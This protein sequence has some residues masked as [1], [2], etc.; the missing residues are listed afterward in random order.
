MDKPKEYAESFQRTPPVKNCRLYCKTPKA[1]IPNVLFLLYFFSFISPQFR[2]MCTAFIS[3]FMPFDFNNHFNIINYI[4]I[5][6]HIYNYT[7]FHIVYSYPFHPFYTLGTRYC[8]WQYARSSP[9]FAPLNT[10]S[11]S[12]Y[13][14]LLNTGSGSGYV[15]ISL[16]AYASAARL[17]PLAI[18]RATPTAQ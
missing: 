16:R 13:F 10:G 15:L 1:E 6:N 17:L 18:R 8:R 5:I 4:N 7:S 2:L 3:S 11:K 12:P 14:A 9:Y